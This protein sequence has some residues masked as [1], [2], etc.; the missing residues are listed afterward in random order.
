MDGCTP[1]GLVQVWE[2]K[3]RTQLD[4]FDRFVFIKGMEFGATCS[5]WDHEGKIVRSASERGS[6]HN[7]VD[8][9]LWTGAGP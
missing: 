1:D 3:L 7:G 5:W 8:F 4:G 9:A 6:P 2:E